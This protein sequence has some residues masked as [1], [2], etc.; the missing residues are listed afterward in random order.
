MASF[1]ISGKALK[2]NRN[3]QISLLAVSVAV[4]ATVMTLFF[5]LKMQTKMIHQS[6]VIA[7]LQSARVVIEDNRDAINNLQDSYDEFNES[8]VLYNDQILGD[9]AVIVLRALPTSYNKGWTQQ[10]WDSFLNKP[11][12]STENRPGHEGATIT[13]SGFPDPVGGEGDGTPLPPAASAE[14][15]LVGTAIPLQF[16]MSIDLEEGGEET[17]S[18]ILEDLDNFIQ[19]VKVRKISLNYSDTD[20][21]SESH[22]SQVTLNLQTYI[23]P[24]RELQFPTEAVSDK[25]QPDCAKGNTTSQDDSEKAE[26][27]ASSDE[28]DQ[29]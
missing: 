8:K 27:D 9:N 6:N 18:N 14:A 29:Q 23:Q 16:T 1:N 10:A 20:D 13:I 12:D 28:G 11:G 24:A 21:G 5:A 3:Q 19:P 17:L 15:D 25:D 22:L 2:V 7:C 4:I 26:E